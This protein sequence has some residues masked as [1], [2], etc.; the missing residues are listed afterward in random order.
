MTTGIKTGIEQAVDTTGDFSMNKLAITVWPHIEALPTASQAVGVL[1]SRLGVNYRKLSF[2]ILR[3]AFLIELVKIPKIETTKFRF[4]WFEQ[5]N[6]DP[7]YCSFEECLRIAEELIISLPQWI[8][9]PNHAEVLTLSFKN[10]MIP[11]EAPLDYRH[12]LTQDGRL[13][14]NGNLVWYYDDLILRTLKL[15]KY[16]TEPATSPDASFFRQLLADKVKVKTYLTDRVLTGSHKTNREKRWETHPQSVHFAERRICMAIEYA[17]VTQIC[18]FEGF[19]ATSLSQLQAANILP[20]TLPTAL[21]P[22]TGDALSYD[23]FRD[24]L[25][26]PQHGKSNFQVG[27]LNPLKLESLN[28][29]AAGH[30]ADNISWISANGNRI[31]GSLSLEDVRAL[32]QRIAEN[33]TRHGWWP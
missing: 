30:T 11:Y 22:I 26:K 33:Y 3:N 17:L 5:L 9:S 10:G 12:R 16:L 15:R 24:E 27:H 32:I 1:R 18:A 29:N 7:R 31:Q 6:Q 21:C 20:A 8:D 28:G 4:R 2:S 23:A 19:P 14:Q 13:H 25:L